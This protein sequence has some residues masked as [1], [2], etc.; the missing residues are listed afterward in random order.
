VSN[1]RQDLGAALWQLGDLVRADEQRR[2]FRAKAY[3]RAVWSLDDLSS[4]LDDP[5]HVM[6]AVRGI[7]PGIIRLI[8][9]FRQ[10]GR[11]GDLD[12]LS[13]LYP[14]DVARL[15]RL[16]RMTAETLRQLKAELGVETGSDLID[17]VGSGGDETLRGVGPATAEKWERVLRLAPTAEATPAFDAQVLAGDLSRHLE[18][19]LSGEA[20]ATGAVRRLDEWVDRIDLVWVTEDFDHARVFRT[21]TAVARPVSVSNG[22]GPLCLA[23]HG[24]VPVAVHLARLRERG[25]NLLVTTGPPSHAGFIVGEWHGEAQTETE[26]YQARGLG[27]VPPPA[28]QL[29]LASSLGVIRSSDLRGDLH[30]HTEWSPDGRMSLQAMLAEAVARDYEYVLVTDHTTGLRFG[31]MDGNALIRQHETIEAARLRFPDLVILHGAELNADREGNLDVDDESLGILDLAVVGLHSHF[32][33][34]RDEQTA[35]VLRALGHPSVRVLAHPTGRRI[36]IR[37]AIDLDLDEVIAGAIEHDVALE[38]NGHRDRL[39][40]SAPLA[41]HAV[42]AGALLALNSDAH[43]VGELRNID[44]AVGTGQKAGV[45]A[46]SVINTLPWSGLVE[47][48]KRQPRT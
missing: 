33:L 22:P 34:D 39:D 8:E 45:G 16:P 20:F 25:L 42:R 13:S 6:R 27:W 30:V 17:A 11:I 1:R 2:S 18:R 40:L 37:P 36:G 31:G 38:V 23:T 15:R 9:E 12:R 46:G 32:D 19:H 26:L 7:G 3:R 4:D 44:N 47:W 24:G 10:T 35:R 5:P 43:R 14:R 41:A 21:E 48:L 29:P 28:R